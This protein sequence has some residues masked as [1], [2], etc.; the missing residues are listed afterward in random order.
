MIKLSRLPLVA[1]CLA[2]LVGPAMI[3]RAQ[4]VPRAP[5]PAAEPAPVSDAAAEVLDVN[6]LATASDDTKT[7]VA[8]EA[9]SEAKTSVI[10]VAK[11]GIGSETAPGV[12]WIA[13]LTLG[14]TGIVLLLTKFTEF[15]P[16]NYRTKAALLAGVLAVA[17]AALAEIS[18]MGHAVTMGAVMTALWNAWSARNKTQVTIDDLKAR[19]AAAG[20]KP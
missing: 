3:L 1:L 11:E 20:I 5:V 9:A 2:L 13:W 6:E 14:L 15:I 19:L 17:V 4:D 7:E 8:T 18:A 10:A 16:P 12:G